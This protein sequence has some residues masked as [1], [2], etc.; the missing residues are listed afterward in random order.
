M[1]HAA[2]ASRGG[3]FR[4]PRLL[5]ASAALAAAALGARA[6]QPA[7]PPRPAPSYTA[8]QAARGQAAY[9]RSCASC[10]GAGL[11][12]GPFAPPLKGPAFLAKYGGKGLDVL[13]TAVR[14]MP[15]ENPGVLP[16]AASADILAYV[17][18]ANAVAPGAAELPADPV[19][20]SGVALPSGSYM[21][22][23]PYAP[24]LIRRDGPDRF[25]GWRP[26]TDAALSAPPPEDWLSWRRTYDAQGFSPLKQIDRTNVHR[27]R[28]AWS[29]TL[30]AGSSLAPPLVRDGVMFV[31][32]MGD[33]IEALDAR[34][35]DLI[36]RYDRALPPGVAPAIRRS[37]ALY[38][39]RLYFGASDVHVVALE[40]RTG[41][42]VWDT[43]IGEAAQRV[44]L[45]GG[46]LV[47]GGKVMIGTTGTGVGAKAPEIV[48]LDAETGRI[49]WR[50]PTIA[51]PGTP[52]GDSW[53]GV[54]AD[55]RSGASVW[56]PGSF[57]PS[58]RLAYFGTGN[59]YDTGPLLHPPPG[60][61]A[62]ALYTDSTLALDPD[63][64]RVVWSFQHMPDDQWDLDWAFE[65]QLVR[66]P[67]KGR[68]RTVALTAGK[69]AI[70]EGLD[71]RTGEYLF[72]IDLG[73]QN[74]VEHID[75][76]T[77]AKTVRA[78]LVPGDGQVKL[79]C[80]HP[81][82]AKSYMPAAY[83]P[84]AELVFVPLTD[85]CADIFPAP[86]G[87]AG[88]S[89]GVNFGVRSRPGS[90]GDYGVLEA[91]DLRTGKPRWTVRRRAPQTSGVLA[92]AGGLVFA[93]AMDRSFSAYDAASGRLLWTARL[94]DASSSSPITYAV[95][96][97]QY[98]AV[99]VGRSGFHVL[100]YEPLTPE[101]LNPREHGAAVWVFELAAP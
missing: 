16:S 57:D 84:A 66:L 22:A 64:G 70:Y 67:V 74:M 38:G 75:P 59:T 87:A 12:D 20:L 33:T 92:T 77:G 11:R 25:A 18:Q 76:T 36:W 35:G 42:V 23:S 1:S 65:R 37:I 90:D 56:T 45:T 5:L 86:E 80:P 7:T 88:L 30:P 101:I 48:G 82:G 99:V 95:G 93:G 32:G 27:L 26:V 31:A 24:P 51:Q 28:L 89:S 72:S 100:S 39:D 85:A 98:V 46:P 15:P 61:T 2:P 29:W 60:T 55:R 53:A 73:F 68:V 47:A 83:D 71:A 8:A 62:D 69:A 41:R 17:A 44:R 3:A 49:A 9:D 50:T 81:A 14:A 19:R 63:T 10:H 97:R 78:A 21:E 79:V 34:T 43:A 52:G 91:L 96:G 40:V 4:R 54:P 94:N 6:Q 58:L 13:W